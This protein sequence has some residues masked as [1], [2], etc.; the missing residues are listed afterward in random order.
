MGDDVF[1]EDIKAN[2]YLLDLPASPVLV[3][4]L[5][6]GQA[7]TLDLTAGLYPRPEKIVWTVR[8]PAGGL[9]TLAPGTEVGG[10]RASQL[11][12]EVGTKYR[13]LSVSVIPS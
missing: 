8:D 10:Y 12:L 5:V 6:E 9:Q 4:D 1:S 2:I 11:E 7:A 13:D 3:S